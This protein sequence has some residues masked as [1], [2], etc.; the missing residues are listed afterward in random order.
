MQ[1]NSWDQHMLTV[2]N[3]YIYGDIG[4]RNL[5]EVPF[6]HSSANCFVLS[7]MGETP[8]REDCHTIVTFSFPE[9]WKKEEKEK[10]ILLCMVIYN[11]NTLCEKCIE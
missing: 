6:A 5:Y 3:S 8:S 10:S 4:W 2:V 9:N 1:K 7:L 11:E